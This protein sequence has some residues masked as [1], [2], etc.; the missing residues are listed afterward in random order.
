MAEIAIPDA[1]KAAPG[2]TLDWQSEP[3]P[4]FPMALSM[5]AMVEAIEGHG[6]A[7][8]DFAEALEVERL[9]EAIRLSSEARCWVWLAD[10]T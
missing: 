7:A 5:Q 4:S 1:F 2:I 3:Q 10:V 9:Q 8:P 6:N